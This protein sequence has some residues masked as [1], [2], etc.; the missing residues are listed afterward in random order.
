MNMSRYARS[1]S[2]FYRELCQ[3][4]CIARPLHEAIHA[5]TKICLGTN[6]KSADSPQHNPDTV[7][8]SGVPELTGPE[9]IFNDTTTS[10]TPRD[11]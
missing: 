7:A 6:A 3:C 9:T 10:D 2:A 5:K 1:R 8:N 4:L 11:S